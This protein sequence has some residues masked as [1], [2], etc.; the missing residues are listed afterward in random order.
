MLFRYVADFTYLVGQSRLHFQVEI[1]ERFLDLVLVAG[2]A[3]RPRVVPR[4]G[5]AIVVSL[6]GPLSDLLVSRVPLPRVA[7]GTAAVRPCQVARHLPI[8]ALL[9][10]YASNDRFSCRRVLESSLTG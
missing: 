1:N 2:L 6:A 3:S 8:S 9:F 10:C 4:G 7:V 5:G